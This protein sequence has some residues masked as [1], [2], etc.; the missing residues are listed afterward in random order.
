MRLVKSRIIDR[1][2]ETVSPGSSGSSS[3]ISVILTPSLWLSQ[4]GGVLISVELSRAN[5]TLHSSAIA[6]A[7]RLAAR[8]HP[9]PTPPPILPTPKIR[10]QPLSDPPA[11]PSPH[12]SRCCCRHARVAPSARS[13]GLQTQGSSQEVA[14][15]CVVEV[16][17][18]CHVSLESH[19]TRHAQ[20]RG[21]WCLR[22]PRPPSADAEVEL[23]F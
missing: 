18:V 13:L 23:H 2:G 5:F 15:C 20:I 6:T 12:T 3:T 17:V 1:R 11:A 14:L 22:L 10:L 7:A 4:G 19:V 9:Y 8:A 16:G 21:G